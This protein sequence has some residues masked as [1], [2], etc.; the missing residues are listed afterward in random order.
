MDTFLLEDDEM[1]IDKL[2][3]LF[4]VK[5]GLKPQTEMLEWLD[6][7]NLI[8]EHRN[9]WVLTSKGQNFLDIVLKIGELL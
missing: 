2:I 5:Q 1:T 4:Q 7:S 9:H 6:K 3:L 8:Y